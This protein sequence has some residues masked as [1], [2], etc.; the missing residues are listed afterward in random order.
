MKRSNIKVIAVATVAIVI[1]LLFS[2]AYV[3]NDDG[4]DFLSGEV[5]II[6]TN[7][8]HGT[9]TRTSGSQG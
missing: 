2:Y 7:D 8:T 6:H 9:M 3:G 1:V 4:D 5:Y